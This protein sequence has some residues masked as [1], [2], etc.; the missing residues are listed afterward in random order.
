MLQTR[1]RDD[2]RLATPPPVWLGRDVHPDD[3]MATVHRAGELDVE[4][5]S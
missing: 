4:I 1:V 2:D 5:V 3:R